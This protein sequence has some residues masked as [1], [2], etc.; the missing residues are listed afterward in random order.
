MDY[1]EELSTKLSEKKA[2]VGV[3][4]V[5]YVGTA[6]AEGA[7]GAGFKVIGFDVSEK[8][9]ADIN[10][11]NHK[12]FSATT[13]FKKLGNCDVICIAVPT[14]LNHDRSPNLAIVENAALTVAAHKKTPCLIILESSVAPG[15]TRTIVMPALG[16]ST[17]EL[18]KKV[19]VGYSPER[20]DPGNQNYTIANTPKI[21][22]GLSAKSLTLVE[23][24]YRQFVTI[25]VPVSSI[26]TAELTKVY[27][28]TFR[29]VNIS[30]ANEMLGYSEKLGVNT[31]EVIRAAATKPF[32]F[33]AHYPS[34][35][36]GGD[37]IPVVPEHLVQSAHALGVNLPVV[38]AAIKV[39]RI[40]PEKVVSKAL[41]MTNGHLANGTAKILLVG[42]TYK[43]N[44]ADIR[45]S[46]ALKIWSLLESKGVH[47]GYHDPYVEHING[48]SSESLENG[49]LG[50]NDVIIVTTPHTNVAYDV[51]MSTGIPILDTHNS[52]AQYN[53]PHIIHL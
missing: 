37:C 6:I 51:L 10:K 33:L 44:V 5:G 46:V 3:V 30:F 50:A 45:E 52:L 13:N 1:F 2:V 31:W 29:L 26:E 24:F 38:E 34:P 42:V 20:I 11:Q 18:E 21:V 48:R 39:N 19:F 7:A 8:R 41:S 40:Q 49:T 43:A 23:T 53:N 28:N 25:V 16:L 12:H 14:P 22:A 35:G 4:G 47:V 36:V 27:E 32:G 17:H 15:T 9:V